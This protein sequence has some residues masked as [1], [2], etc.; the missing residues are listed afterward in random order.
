MEWQLG[1]RRS[2]HF[3]GLLFIALLRPS[4]FSD[5]Y[6]LFSNRKAGVFDTPVTLSFSSV[7]I[8]NRAQFRA[9]LH[10][11]DQ[12]FPKLYPETNFQEDPRR[13][14]YFYPVVVSVPNK[15]PGDAVTVQVVIYP[16]DP[17]LHPYAASG[18]FDVV[19]GTKDEPGSLKGMPAMVVLGTPF[20]ARCV[21]EPHQPPSDIPSSCDFPTTTNT[22]EIKI[23]GDHVM[24]YP[25]GIGAASFWYQ[26]E[27]SEDLITW[28][29]LP[30]AIRDTVRPGQHRYYRYHKPNQTTN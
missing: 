26:A 13:A 30:S 11:S 21:L 22:F 16:A 20:W 18:P 7:S 19:L 9:A 1:H 25:W 12:G 17:A 27:Y 28:T 8:T 14:G 4:S 2:L 6:I 10:L 15:E 3:F 23:H 29:P 5:G 24:L